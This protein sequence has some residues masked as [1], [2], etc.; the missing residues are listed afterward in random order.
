MTN[1]K[2][3]S[4]RPAKHTHTQTA[5]TVA[6]NKLVG[7]HG[8]QTNLAKLANVRQSTLARLAQGSVGPTPANVASLLDA[9]NRRQA[10]GLLR[11]WL[12]DTLG[13]VGA[14]SRKQATREALNYFETVL[15]YPVSYS[16]AHDAQTMKE[17]MVL[18]AT[19]GI[20]KFDDFA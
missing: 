18:N 13:E 17:V 6:V 12:L 19:E 3:R 11:A 10:R 15:S 9:C 16:R 4:G 14:I 8:T 2:K 7:I 5:F 1:A 20:G